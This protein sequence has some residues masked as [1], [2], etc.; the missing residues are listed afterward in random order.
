MRKKSSSSS[1][2]RKP[3]LITIRADQHAE[4]G[5]PP[6]LKMEQAISAGV[7][8][9]H[10]LAE[11]FD[12][13]LGKAQL[14]LEGPK[15]RVVIEAN[16]IAT[17]LESFRGKL[18]FTGPSKVEEYRSGVNLLTSGLARLYTRTQKPEYAVAGLVAERGKIDADDIPH[19]LERL[20]VELPFGSIDQ[21]IASDL[22]QRSGAKLVPT[23]KSLHELNLIISE[24]DPIS[25]LELHSG[26]KVHVIYRDGTISKF[27]PPRTIESLIR[28]G[29][30]APIA[31]RIIKRLLQILETIKPKYIGADEISEFVSSELLKADTPGTLQDRYLKY[32]SGSNLLMNGKPVTR[33]SIRSIV[34]THCRKLGLV[35]TSG[36]EK[37]MADDVFD[38]LKLLAS[39]VP[40]ETFDMDME[41]VARLVGYRIEGISGVQLVRD[42]GLSRAISE[43]YR[44]AKNAARVGVALSQQS[45]DQLLPESLERGQIMRACSWFLQAELLSVRRCPSGRV[46]QDA[47]KVISDLTGGAKRERQVKAL[48]RDIVSIMS[49]QQVS[50]NSV[51]RLFRSVISLSSS[52]PRIA[53]SRNR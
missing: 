9:I 5:T 42:V 4:V 34:E 6:F 44:R 15:D 36:H 23:S 17:R 51:N 26:Q 18:E 27:D 32:S 43:L 7:D 28:A 37:E 8:G 31:M 3:Y 49:K 19:E 21:A 11:H 1:P 2:E 50:W 33:N 22:I 35:L 12:E 39:G 38:S 45:R 41:V 14:I 46:I 53:T 25:D 30:G 48:C 13:Q 47:T 20:G 16:Q 24:R 52:P 10:L 40:G 29:V